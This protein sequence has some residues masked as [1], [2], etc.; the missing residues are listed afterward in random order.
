MHLRSFVLAMATLI[1]L[2]LIILLSPLIA[3]IAVAAPAIGLRRYAM[4]NTA[5]AQIQAVGIS[6]Q[7]GGLILGLAPVSWWS[8]RR[9]IDKRSLWPSCLAVKLFAADYDRGA[10]T[11]FGLNLGN[12]RFALRGAGVHGRVSDLSE[13]G[14][15]FWHRPLRS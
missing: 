13:V 14:W 15:S 2:A 11:I 7:I 10:R 9:G 6:L 4:G 8:P 1:S 3:L 5:W 12:A